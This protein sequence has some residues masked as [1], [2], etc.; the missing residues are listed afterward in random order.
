MNRVVVVSICF[1]LA[2]IVAHAQDYTMYNSYYVNPYLNN[3]AEAAT[4]Y[5]NV[6][7]SHR[8]Q[9]MGFRGA[10]RTTTASFTTLLDDSRAGIGMKASCFSRGILKT[11][12]FQFSYAY[13]IPFNFTNHLYLGLSGGVMCNDIDLTNVDTSDPAIVGYLGHNVQPVG[14]FGALLRL[15]SGINLGV[16][17]PQIFAQKYA[18]ETHFQ[19]RATA[20]TDEI[21]FSA[22]YKRKLDT[23]FPNRRGAGRRRSFGAAETF[24]PLELY[25]VY[26]LPK[27][28]DGQLEGIMKINL[29]SHCWLAG[30]YR[31]NNGFLGSFGLQVSNVL[32]ITYCYESGTEMATDYAPDSH[33]LQLALRVGKLKKLKRLAP[34]L[35][36]T[37]KG[38]QPEHHMARFQQPSE[39]TNSATDTKTYYVVIRGFNDF[40]GADE[41]KGKLIDQKYNA[42]VYYHDKDKKFYVYVYASA[43]PSQAHHEARQLRN[44]TKLK[45]ARVLTVHGK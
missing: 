36:S 28:G 40:T 24:A 25:A 41:Y 14:N 35:Q 5:A 8:Q 33:E 32:A 45:E 30:G 18:A 16:T 39:S 9:W 10:P 13:T 7:I 31:Q 27:F 42:Q 44:F 21:I 37:L 2:S 22:Y 20:P 3:P 6:Q 17:F 11:T 19:N 29:A 1:V 12:D 34:I 15:Q 4:S 38:K 43:K 23:P 26:R